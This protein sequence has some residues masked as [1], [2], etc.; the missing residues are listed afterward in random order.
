[1]DR[2]LGFAWAKTYFQV[3]EEG[4][5]RVDSTNQRVSEAC[6]RVVAVFCYALSVLKLLLHVSLRSPKVPYRSS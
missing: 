3:S 4:I 6:G 2:R 1:M 5:Y